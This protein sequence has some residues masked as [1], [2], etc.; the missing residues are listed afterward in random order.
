[1]NY[2]LLH[3]KEWEQIGEYIL[4][5]NQKKRLGVSDIYKCVSGWLLPSKKK[6]SWMHIRRVV[7]YEMIHNSGWMCTSLLGT[8]KPHCKWFSRIHKPPNLS[9]DWKMVF[10]MGIYSTFVRVAH[11]WLVPRHLVSRP[12]KARFWKGTTGFADTD[13]LPRWI[14]SSKKVQT[15]QKLHAWQKLTE[16]LHSHIIFSGQTQHS[17]FS[18]SSVI[19]E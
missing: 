9:V 5:M 15:I 11:E 12:T 4:C 3:T 14:L 16:W 17:R 10:R 2:D 13:G 1:M 7:F 8:R 19:W 18:V 6:A